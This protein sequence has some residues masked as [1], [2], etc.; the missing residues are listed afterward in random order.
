M[1]NLKGRKWGVIYFELILKYN[2]VHLNL[3][4]FNVTFN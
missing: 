1:E 4:S 3:I 2:I